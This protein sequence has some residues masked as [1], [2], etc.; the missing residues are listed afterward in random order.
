MRIIGVDLHLR[1]QRI[2]MFDTETKALVEK[3]LKHEGDEVREFYSAL[4]HPVQVGIEASGSMYWFLELLG[5]LGIDR[6]V[7]HPA[8]IRA[9]EPRK[10]KHDRRDALLLLKLQ[11]ENRFPSIWMPSSELRDLHA[12]VRHRHQWVR[13][14]TRVQNALQA[15]AVSR[16]L[17]R[18]P[19][20]WSQTGQHAIASLPLAPHAAH[21][22]NELQ[23]LYR[24]LSTKI[25]ELDKRV[26]DQALQRPGANLL[27]T[28]PGVGPVTALATDVFLGD[29]T[30]FDDGKAVVSYIG[31]IPSEY[32]SGDR[33]RL[34][35][36][37]KQGNPLLRFLW[38][39][40]GIHAVRRDPELKRF[41]RRKLQQ[42]GL[43]KARVA[44]ARKL[45]I[46]LWIMLRAQI[47]Y[48]EF[49]RRGQLRQKSGGARAGMPEG[50][51]SPATS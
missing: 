35:G 18:G 2:A 33:Q 45:G 34:G 42:K 48:Q 51:H 37:S 22:R 43:G 7:G 39:E 26:M 19:S 9:A 10:Q 31:M 41:Y 11:I 47:D 49:C 16:G 13:M 46:R 24:T 50:V 8:K 44:V 14:R 17:R 29:P 40:A 27:M 5:E 21:R 32:S 30:R 28:H 1:Q 23:D 12:L 3:T 15:I 6:Q 25:D 4:P 36:L 20:L 38:C